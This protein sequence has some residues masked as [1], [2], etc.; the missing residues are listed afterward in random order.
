MQYASS[1]GSLPFRFGCL[2]V[3]TGLAVFLGFLLGLANPSLPKKSS[4]SRSK[5]IVPR[6]KAISS[7]WKEFYRRDFLPKLP[8]SLAKVQLSLEE[9]KWPQSIPNL[10]LALQSLYS[11]LWIIQ[12][13]FQSKGCFSDKLSN[14]WKEAQL[15]SPD[16]AF[17]FWSKVQQERLSRLVKST[18][19]LNLK[20][21]LSLRDGKFEEGLGLLFLIEKKIFF[22]LQRC[23][24]L[25]RQV[26][27]LI[28]L[29]AYIHKQLSFA[30]V[31]PQLSEDQRLKIFAVLRHWEHR[32]RF[33]TGTLF[34]HLKFFHRLIKHHLKSSKWPYFWNDPKDT[35]E[36][37]KRYILRYAF[38]LGR[39][40]VH[41]KDWKLYPI[42]IYIEMLKRHPSLKYFRYNAFG[43]HFVQQIQPIYRSLAM[44]WYKERCL[45]ALH[46]QRWLKELQQRRIKLSPALLAQPSLNP[47]T[48]KAFS[49]HD[50][51]LTACQIPLALQLGIDPKIVGLGE[52]WPLPKTP[53][54]DSPSSPSASPNSYRHRRYR[55]RYRHRRR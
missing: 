47:F 5:I 34:R 6:F 37:L 45:F 38:L 11:Q 41:R 4:L 27:T 42:E 36:L 19:L 43:R 49:A 14:Y 51:P 21:I 13:T 30:L 26:V 31:L 22:Y 28:Y 44:L 52:K 10:K 53:H 32:P 39:S 50:T 35:N 29:L 40:P 24:Y 12:R 16:D 2:I 48:R 54:I 9:G 1:R 20:A 15:H 55:R 46:R 18:K 23:S 33:L 8:T 25:P 17:F 3:L 7:E